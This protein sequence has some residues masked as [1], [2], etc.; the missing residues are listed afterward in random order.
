MNAINFPPPPPQK[1]KKSFCSQAITC[2]TLFILSQ[3]GVFFCCLLWLL[4]CSPPPPPPADNSASIKTITMK[5]RGFI[6]LQRKFPLRSATRGFDVKGRG[7]Y[8]MISKRRPSWIR[9]LGFLGF[10]ISPK[11]V[12]I[13]LALLERL[14]W[15][16]FKLYL[17]FYFFVLVNWMRARHLMLQGQMDYAMMYLDRVSLQTFILSFTTNRVVFNKPFPSCCEPHYESEAK[18]KAFNMKNSFVCI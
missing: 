14:S 1:K 2:W 17:F 9:R 4:G 15:S 8:V 16:T 12:R 5:H 18:C 10:W 11:I 3:A 6:V 7:Y 13:V